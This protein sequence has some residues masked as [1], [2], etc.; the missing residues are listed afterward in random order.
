MSLSFSLILRPLGSGWRQCL[1]PRPISLLGENCPIRTQ[2]VMRGRASTNFRS[3][4]VWA[5]PFFQTF[6]DFLPWIRS[7]G[8]CAMEKLKTNHRETA[9]NPESR[10]MVLLTFRDI[11]IDFTEEEWECLQPAQKNLYNDVMLENYRN[12]AFLAMTLHDTQEYISEKGIKHI[13]HKVISGKYKS[14]DL[15]YLQQK[16]IWETISESEHQKSYKKSG[17]VHHQRIHTGEK[18]YKCKKC[19]KALSL[20]SSLIRHSRTHTGEKPYKCKECGKAFSLNSHLIRHSKTH[21]GERP[22]KCKECGK[23][24]IEKTYLFRHRRTHT[25]EKPY[26]CIECGKN[27]MG[28]TDGFWLAYTGLRVLQRLTLM[29]PITTTTTTTIIIIIAISRSIIAL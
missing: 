23:A 26:K 3:L 16:K 1:K 19:G 17:L 2:P 18:P 12:F 13:F 8:F 27:R 5:P 28:Y 14:Y 25:G 9:E 22:Y 15:D 11:A 10:E 6:L 24:F 21:T 4:R 29:S 20:K 7:P